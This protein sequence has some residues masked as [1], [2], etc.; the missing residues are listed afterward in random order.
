M[1][2]ARYGKTRY[3]AVYDGATLV[4]VCL[5]KKGAL[6]VVQRLQGLDAAQQWQ[7]TNGPA[8]SGQD[9]GATGA[10]ELF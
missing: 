6:E 4:C 1:R 7:N 9:A 5:Y 2:I 3:W 10:C 8:D